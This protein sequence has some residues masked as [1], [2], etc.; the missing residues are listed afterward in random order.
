MTEFWLILG[1]LIIGIPGAVFIVMQVIS[2]HKRQVMAYEWSTAEVAR[3]GQ[4]LDQLERLTKD[5]QKRIND[6]T[7][8]NTVLRAEVSKLERM[9]GQAITGPSP[10]DKKFQAGITNAEVRRAHMMGQKH[11]NLDDKWAEINY[12]D[13]FA[14]NEEAAR[15]VLL[16]KYPPE[17][18]FVISS[19]TQQKG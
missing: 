3:R 19:L 16:R 10:D 18:G 11:R 12:E 5:A 7:K 4:R 8:E 2:A 9:A 13:I 1:A 14:A 17:R 15:K 6:L